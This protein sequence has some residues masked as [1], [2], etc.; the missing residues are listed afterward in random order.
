MNFKYEG[1]EYKFGYYAKPRKDNYYITPGSV[2]TKAEYDISAQLMIVLPIEILHYF[3]GV[4]FRETGDNR[5]ARRGEW[6][7]F[8]GQPRITQVWRTMHAYTILEPV[9]ILDAAERYYASDEYVNHRHDAQ[10]E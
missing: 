2:V 9:R 1:K 4:T 6:Y 5:K 8:D 7:L 10:P 3:G